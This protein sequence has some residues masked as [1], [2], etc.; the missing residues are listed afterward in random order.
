LTL[1][2]N[3]T[4]GFMDYLGQG[5]HVIDGWDGVGDEPGQAEDG[6]DHNDDSEDEEVQVI[7]TA[8]LQPEQQSSHS[9][10]SA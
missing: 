4:L 5:L 1:Y 3:K 10:S 2:I 7:T 9:P 8:L 6:G